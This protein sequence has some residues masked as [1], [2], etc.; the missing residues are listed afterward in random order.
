MKQHLFVGLGNPG[1]KYEM[2]RHNIGFLTIKLLSHDLGVSLREDKRFLGWVA[3]KQ[4]AELTVHLLLPATYMNESGNAV[5]RYVDFYKLHPEQI[6]IVTD[7]IAL[8]F[9]QLRLRKQ[10]SAG[11]HNG[12]KSVQAHLGTTHYARLRMGIGEM[13]EGSLVDY[14]LD[15]FTQ[16]ERTALP[17]FIEKGASVLKRLLSEDINHVM[18]DVNKNLG[19][20]H[21]SK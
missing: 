11:G 2:T 20:K 13:E 1:K 16:E 6:V 18:N 14:V 12:M 10:G 8:P 19:E 4:T 21:E 9:G 7:D 3:K 17:E 5:K 15:M